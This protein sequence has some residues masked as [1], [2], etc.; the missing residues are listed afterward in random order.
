MV[1]QLKYKS[2]SNYTT[3]RIGGPAEFLALAPS[4][5]VLCV[6]ARDARRRRMPWRLLG[7]G[8]NVLAPDEGLAGTTIVFRDETPPTRLDDRRV[9]VSG[10]FALHDFILFLAERGLGGLEALAGIPGTVGGAIFGNAGAYGTAIGDRVRRVRL[11]TREGSVR[12]IA[13]D[14][15]E[16]SYRHSRLKEEPAAVIEATIELAPADRGR[17]LEAVEEKLA[18]RAAKHPDWKTTPT[19]G[20]WFKNIKR[21][22]GTVVAAGRLLEEAGCKELRVG[23]AFLWQ[24][25]ANIVVTDGHASAA[26]VRELTAQMAARVLDRFGIQL[27]PEVCCL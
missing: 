15:L 11:L 14:E 27:V 22:D 1:Q 13:G 9:S 2:L 5:G 12:E 24:S 19:A 17:L 6:A 16:F 25:H 4:A 23:G 7:H 18:D 3:L 10:G 21:D 8:S 20:S 26:D